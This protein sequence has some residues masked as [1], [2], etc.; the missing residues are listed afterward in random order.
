[1]LTITFITDIR[2]FSNETIK[3]QAKDIK[4]KA[5]VD[6]SNYKISKIPSPDNIHEYKRY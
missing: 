3:Q 1:M 4:E 6:K 5:L 2:V